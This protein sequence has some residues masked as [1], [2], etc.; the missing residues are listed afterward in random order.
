MFKLFNF[1]QKKAEKLHVLAQQLDD[2]GFAEEA[3][4]LYQQAIALDPA[5]YESYYNI[6]LI[7]KYQ[8][9][10]QK[11]F[12][13]NQKA[14]ALNPQNESSRW[15]LAIAA[16]ALRDWPT[17]RKLWRENGLTLDEGDG[18]IV[19][20]FGQTPIRLNPDGKPEVVWAKRLDPVRAEI[21]SV[22]LP[23]SG[24]GAGDV[25][26]HD[27]A[28]V[29]Y[30][31]YGED[32]RPVFNALELFTQSKFSTFE[33]SVTVA[34]QA[35]IELLESLL[36]AH[37]MIAEDWT[38]NYR[39]LCKACS[40]G[41]PHDDHDQNGNQEWVPDHAIGIAAVSQQAIT[42]VFS[43]WEDPSRRTLT[44][45]SCVFSRE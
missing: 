17:A 26:L 20:D 15:N 19:C 22:P 38:T 41:R 1:A 32:E 2:E 33:A 29:G 3:L 43:L 37:G 4:E 40:E 25:V 7:Y 5:K 9:N 30:R 45:L 13:Y 18:P 11:S 34:E 10:W 44:K 8:N 27:G 6:G 28:A 36:E 39:V 23:A 31:Q 21:V 35:D 14:Y 42:E 16:T 24:Y 12:D